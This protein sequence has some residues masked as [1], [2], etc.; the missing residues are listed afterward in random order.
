MREQLVRL[1]SIVL[2]LAGL[3]FMAWTLRNDASRMSWSALPQPGILVI[4]VAVLATSLLVSYLMWVLV[5]DTTATKE[6]LA[7]YL[8]AQAAKYIPGGV[9]HG[10]GQVTSHARASESTGILEAGVGYVVQ[11][12]AQ[13]GAG[14]LFGL[15][16]LVL[17]MQ[18]TPGTTIPILAVVVSAG[19]LYRPGMQRMFDIVARFRPTWRDEVSLPSQRRLALLAGLG[20]VTLALQGI[21]LSSLVGGEAGASLLEVV[22]AYGISWTI[23]WLVIPLPAGLGLRE[24]LLVILLPA[25]DPGVIVAASIAMRVGQVVAEGMMAAIGQAWLRLGAGVR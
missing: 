16:A 24:F 7:A 19:L 17:G 5:L 12:L 22:A 3:G 2:V 10:I 6:S 13:V 20:T 21:V 15:L 23:G 8:A 18:T 11:A 9:W 14:S 25:I 1:L 4:L